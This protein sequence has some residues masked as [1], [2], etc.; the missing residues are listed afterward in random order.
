MSPRLTFGDRWP[1][2]LFDRTLTAVLVVIAVAESLVASYRPTGVDGLW[3]SATGVLTCLPVVLRRTHPFAGLV[4]SELAFVLPH[5][6]GTFDTLFVGG[7]LV[8]VLQV[9]SCAEYA[10]RPWDLL[11]LVTLAPL[12]ASRI[13]LD[14]A[15][16]PLQAYL[17]DMLVFGAGWAFGSLLRQLR[18]QN[19]ALR[20]ALDEAREADRL[21]TEAAIAAERDELARELH[22]VVA[23][24]VTVMVLQAGSARVQLVRRPEASRQAMEQ[25][26]QTGREA[27]VELRRV[28]GLLRAEA[29]PMGDARGMAD[30]P[31]LAEQLRSSGLDVRTTTE[32]DAVSL[33]PAL[34][35]T[36][37]R[38]VQEG[39]T[40][41]VKHGA[42]GSTV[43]TVRY[44]PDRLELLVENPSDAK[45]RAVRPASARGFGLLGMRE[46]VAAFGGTISV[47]DDGGTFRLSAEL[48]LDRAAT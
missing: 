38:I 45:D 19:E 10:R 28:L 41:A 44:G 22:D 6:F 48:P 20:V 42:A 21:R 36:A 11:A 40:N 9:S 33:S 26:E 47:D 43:V 18:T 24:C 12:V 4:L 30:L 3:L 31:E 17:F 14:P 39:L 32:G 29:E 27:L 2:R 25:V 13:A 1:A 34:E 8:L 15:A 5:A 35:R 46:R 37:F 7:F 23:H 16:E